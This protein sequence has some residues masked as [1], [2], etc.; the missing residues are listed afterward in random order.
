[1]SDFTYLQFVVAFVVP[2]ALALAVAVFAA[3]GE[4][5]HAAGIALLASVA[6]AY[7]TPWDNYLVAKGVWRYGDGVVTA[8]IWHAPVGEYLFV[9]L[10]TLVAGLWF[11]RVAAA[12]EP[13]TGGA[14]PA[15]D[16]FLPDGDRPA[17]APAHDPDVRGLVRTVLERP[18][19]GSLA[20]AGA[21]TGVALGG[22]ALLG[23]PDWYYLGAILAWAGPVLA[24]QWAYGGRYLYRRRR[25]CAV[26]VLGPTLYLAVVDRIA[27]DAGLWRLSPAHTSG[28]TVFGLPIEEGAFF[29]LTNLMLAQGFLLF[30]RVTDRWRRTPASADEWG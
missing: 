18:V 12:G 13:A 14:T 3:G 5:G 8:R 2:P 29:L 16:R 17:A 28:L 1:M 19:R 9:L 30:F 10:Q 11:A 15:G 23:V 7:T 6:L 4:R 22:L 26:A 21:W 20:G 25:R 24:L 27:I